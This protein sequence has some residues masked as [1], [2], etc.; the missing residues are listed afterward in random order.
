MHQYLRVQ[1]WGFQCMKVKL[2][3]YK[4]RLIT[5]QKSLNMKKS[6][7]FV[8]DIFNLFYYGII[9]FINRFQLFIF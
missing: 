2:N 1:K 8:S 7:Y 3:D 5:L 9:N 6:K 4:E